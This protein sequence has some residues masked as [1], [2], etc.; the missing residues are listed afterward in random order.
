MGKDTPK[1]YGL[2]AEKHFEAL[3]AGGEFVTSRDA[4]RITGVGK[5]TAATLMK[6]FRSNWQAV[7]AAPEAD[8]AAE[9][10]A[11]ALLES[12]K[13]KTWTDERSGTVFTNL[14]EYG[15]FTLTEGQFRAIKREYSKLWGGRSATMQ[16][17]VYR[18]GFPT[19]SAF[20]QFRK[21]HE[22]RQTSIPFTDTEIETEEI[23]SLVERTLESRKQQFF[24]TL[25]AKER[26]A[27][28]RDAEKWRAFEVNAHMIAA[29]VKG[30]A[31]GKPLPIR[32]APQDAALFM[33]IIN[34]QDLH[35]GKL[36]YNSRG[37]RT[38]DRQESARRFRVASADLLGQVSRHGQPETIAL[39]VGGDLLHSDSSALKTTR[40]TEQGGQSDGSYR[41]ILAESVGLVMEQIKAARVIAPVQVWWSTATTTNNQTS[42][43]GCC[44]SKPLRAITGS[45]W[46]TR[47]TAA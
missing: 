23:G 37:E 14:G 25:Q 9:P 17:V 36:A 28:K 10:V 19:I 24:L 26:D 29:E 35:H 42:F 13:T 45:T 30:L 22:L 44:W 18:H 46:C 40:G 47:V 6:W 3:Y 43:L 12:D 11:E 5:S 15:I 2:L 4:A 7:Q 1:H 27:E 16:E 38:Y 32:T 34:L 41:E 33:A 20:D 31:A 21:I 8:A 39:V